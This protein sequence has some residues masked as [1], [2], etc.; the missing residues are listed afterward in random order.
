MT[1]WGRRVEP[2]CCRFC[3]RNLRRQL[4]CAFLRPFQLTLHHA[5]RLHEWYLFSLVSVVRVHE[6]LIMGLTIEIGIDKRFYESQFACMV[7]CIKSLSENTRTAALGTF[8]FVQSSGAR[9]TTPTRVKVKSPS[10]WTS[11]PPSS[12]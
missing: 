5:L 9:V 12:P 10:I 7:F 4:K 1:C 8:G 6:S 3:M 11:A 2:W